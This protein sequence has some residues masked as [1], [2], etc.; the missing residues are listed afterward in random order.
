MLNNKYIK[1]RFNIFFT[2]GTLVESSIH[3]IVDKG[4]TSGYQLPGL[5]T[6][7]LGEV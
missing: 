3:E 6:W 2:E 4:A 5:A 7:Q 1:I